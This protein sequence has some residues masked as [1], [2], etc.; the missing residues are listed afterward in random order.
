MARLD[1]EALVLRVV[2]Y[3]ES[4]RIA[5]LLTPETSRLTV[6]AK[7]ARRSR[8]RFPGALDLLCHV[9]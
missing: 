9:A 1:T 3:G 4:D 2:D 8:K 5:H 7:G 6:I